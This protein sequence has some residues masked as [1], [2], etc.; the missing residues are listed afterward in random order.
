VAPKTISGA[1]ECQSLA[2]ALT[3]KFYTDK[4]HKKRGCL[5]SACTMLQ[6]HRK[7]TQ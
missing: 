6:R 4:H 1:G 2:L 7:A 5:Q 3:R